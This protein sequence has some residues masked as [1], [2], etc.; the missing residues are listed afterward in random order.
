MSLI[1]KSL[2]KSY[3]DNKVLNDINL[4]FKQGEISGIVGEN[5][6]GKTTIFKCIA[7]L[8]D[9]NGSV[10]Y[11]GEILKNTVGFLATNPDFISKITGKEYLQLLCNARDIKI[12]DFDEKNIFDLPLKQYCETYSTGMKKKLALTGVLL[13]NNEVF[14]LDEPFNG[15]DIHSNIIIKE[16]LEKLKEL[17]KTIIISSHIFSALNETCDNLHYLKNGTIAKSVNKNEFYLIENE[18]KNSGIKSRIDN[19]II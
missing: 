17:N 18:M 9:Y 11:K 2:S 13:Q 8:E 15:V 10:I 6:A 7:G 4:H 12:K 14:I 19:L 3:I 5:G 1:I 16:I